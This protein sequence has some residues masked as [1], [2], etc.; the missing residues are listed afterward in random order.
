M[1]S[2]RSKP[3]A[4]CDDEPSRVVC[5]PHQHHAAQAR[6]AEGAHDPLG[7]ALQVAR[8]RPYLCNGEFQ[9]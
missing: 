1:A 3:I 7:V 6:L 9:G 2:R 4:R 5:D 8:P